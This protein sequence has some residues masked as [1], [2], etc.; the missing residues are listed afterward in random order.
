MS[1]FIREFSVFYKMEQRYENRTI[2]VKNEVSVKK[3]ER[4]DV[5]TTK[6][7][8]E[9]SVTYKVKYGAFSCLVHS[10]W[11]KQKCGREPISIHKRL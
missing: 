9:S 2:D 11:Y 10:K 6:A 5:N 3:R 1:I 4:E 7:S 8:L